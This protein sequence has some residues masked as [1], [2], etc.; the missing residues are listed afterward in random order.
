MGYNKD[1]YKRIREEYAT[2]GF[3]AQEEADVRRAELYASIPELR[4][5]DL[6]LSEFGLRIMQAALRREDTAREVAAL[7]EENERM[8]RA[9]RALLTHHGF[10]ED[11]S[12]PKYECALCNDTGYVGIKMCSCMRKGL[13]EAG[14]ESSGLL[15]LLRKQSFENFSLDYYKAD[16]KHYQSMR[17]T[18][19]NLH[20]YAHSFS[21]EAGKPMPSSLLFLGGTGLGRRIFLRRSHAW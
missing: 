14:M 20:H 5:M 12:E 17:E 15:T 21:I 11:Y 19:R 4:E 16:E 10:P 2:K 7:R 8:Q 3:R 9:R 13:I 18:Y 1:N 6:R